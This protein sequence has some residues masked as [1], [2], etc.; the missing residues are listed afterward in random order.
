MIKQKNLEEHPFRE[1][2]G[3]MWCEPDDHPFFQSTVQY[4]FHQVSALSTIPNSHPFLQLIPE[5]SVIQH[6][7]IVTETFVMDNKQ[8]NP[9]L[10][11]NNF[12]INWGHIFSLRSIPN[13]S[14]RD[15]RTFWHRQSEEITFQTVMSSLPWEH[16]Y[17]HGVAEKAK[18]TDTVEQDTRQPELKHRVVVEA[19][20]WLKQR[21]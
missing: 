9:C 15:N 12:V 5:N 1:G 16:K 20:D 6:Y 11:T 17:G 3:F 14:V 7:C 4:P 19:G 21:W 13:M 10:I 18:K 8:K 2:G